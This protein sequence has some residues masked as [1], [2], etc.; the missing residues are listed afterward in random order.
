MTVGQLVYKVFYKPTLS[1]RYNLNHFG[2]IGWYKMRQGEKQMKKAAANIDPLKLSDDHLLTC[3]YLTGANYWHQTIICAYSLIKALEGQV[4]IKIYSDGTLQEQHIALI[5]RMAPGIEFVSKN[6]V[7]EHLDSFLP[8]NKFP[9]LHYLR[10]WHPFFQRLID[11]HA[12]ASWTIHLDS[13]MIFFARPNHIIDAYKTKRAVYMQE[14]LNSSYFVDDVKT[15]ADKYNMNCISFVNGG[16]IGYNSNEVDYNDLEEKA[17]LLLENYPGAGPAQVEQTIMSYLLFK[18]NARPLSK[19]Q[20]TIFYDSELSL[21]DNHIVRH[22]IFK[23]KLPY[24]DTE[25]KKAIR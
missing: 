1:I 15:L 14:Q 9:T 3:C 22:Y 20:Y 7:D 24:F 4:K 25:W 21:K 6:K 16:I 18:Q 8:A 19:E 13:D 2:L 10:Q 11:I 12:S 5:K 23:A 17:K